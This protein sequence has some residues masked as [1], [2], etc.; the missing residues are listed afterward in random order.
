METTKGNFWRNLQRGSFQEEFLR[1]TFWG[2]HV[3]EPSIGN[4]L[5]KKKK[6]QPWRNLL[7]RTFWGKLSEG[8]VHED[9]LLET[10]KG[11][12][13]VEN[14]S[15]SL[16]E[17][18]TEEWCWNW[19]VDIRKVSLVSIQSPLLITA[20]WS[21][22]RNRPLSSLIHAVQMKLP[23]PFASRGGPLTQT[24]PSKGLPFH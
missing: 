23:W 15:K 9:L 17:I 7:R 12:L 14:L 5:K 13:S 3:G 16:S 21:S 1:R 24:W 8:K 10:F 6:K 2:K 20:H 11:K 19:M 4:L 22:F 18:W